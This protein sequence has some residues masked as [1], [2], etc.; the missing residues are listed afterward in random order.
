MRSLPRRQMRQLM[1]AYVGQPQGLPPVD[2][3]S[4]SEF[5]EEFLR[6]G[7]PEFRVAFIA[8]SLGLLLLSILRTG[9]TFSRLGPEGRQELLN[10]CFNSRNPLVRGMAVLPGLAFFMSYYRRPE[11]AVP[12]G[13]D[14]EG[15]KADAEL[16]KV[17]RDHD[18]P[19]KE[20]N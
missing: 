7:A 12:L 8:S 2:F 4:Q 6:A 18:L 3:D 17:S 10:K 20:V 14:S 11:V 5:I 9:K 15:L 13:F 1:E 16:R 19:A